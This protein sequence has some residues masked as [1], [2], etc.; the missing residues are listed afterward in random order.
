MAATENVAVMVTLAATD[1]E[2]DAADVHGPDATQ[3]RRASG[4]A[5]NRHTPNADFNGG[6]SF[7]FVANDGSGSDSG[8]PP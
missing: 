8:L 2:N 3:Q 6:S 1:V 4:T 5:A 7:T